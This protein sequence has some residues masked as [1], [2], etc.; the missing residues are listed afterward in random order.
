MN[1]F[2]H[3]NSYLISIHQCYN[4]KQNPKPCHAVSKGL[5]D[6]YAPIIVTTYPRSGT[7]GD[8][9]GFARVV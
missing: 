5:T 2:R 1:L 4:I 9:W 6:Y 3:V 7:D 8:Y